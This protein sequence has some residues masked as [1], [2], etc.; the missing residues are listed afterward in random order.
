MRCVKDK[1][2]MKEKQIKPQTKIYIAHI[3]KTL[4]RNSVI[5]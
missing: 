3:F 4:L 2:A 1:F 5:F